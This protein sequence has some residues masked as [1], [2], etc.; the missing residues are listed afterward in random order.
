MLESAKQKRWQIFD[1]QP[2]EIREAISEK[3][4][5]HPGIKALIRGDD[6][7]CKAPNFSSVMYITGRTGEVPGALF[8]P[9]HAIRVSS[10]FLS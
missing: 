3:K 5:D 6:G 9:R 10:I 1:D 4:F 7:P 2:M 8:K